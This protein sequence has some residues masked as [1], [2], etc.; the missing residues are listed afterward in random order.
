MK[1]K[2]NSYFAADWEEVFPGCFTEI[3]DYMDLPASEPV[4]VEVQSS[5]EED[6]DH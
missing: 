6:S 4:T 3:H 2:R 5:G 1:S